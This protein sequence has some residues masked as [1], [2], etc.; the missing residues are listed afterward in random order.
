MLKTQFEV[1][2]VQF[3]QSLLEYYRSGSDLRGVVGLLLEKHIR[4][5]ID[6][7]KKEIESG[8]YDR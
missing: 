4:T 2:Y 3:A 6:T 8:N 5:A 7:V 1:A